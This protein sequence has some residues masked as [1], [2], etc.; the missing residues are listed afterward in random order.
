M[1]AVY[2]APLCF[3]VELLLRK[4]L[5]THS[6]LTSAFETSKLS[7]SVFFLTLYIYIYISMKYWFSHFEPKSDEQKPNL[8]MLRA[9]LYYRIV[10]RPLGSWK[11]AGCSF[12]VSILYC[13]FEILQNF[14]NVDQIRHHLYNCNGVAPRQPL[15][16][17]TQL[18]S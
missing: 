13:I 17:M 7:M 15:Q 11:F 2:I 8:K 6:V 18:A 14:C 12:L 3:G 5:Y 1:S 4:H 10:H 9:F 16:N